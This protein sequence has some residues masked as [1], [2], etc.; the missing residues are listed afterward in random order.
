MTKNIEHKICAIFPVPIYFSKL[1]RNFNQVELNAFKD[2]EMVKNYAN[3][4]SKDTYILDKKPLLNLKNE[5]LRVVEDYYE[6]VVS[7][8]NKIKPFITQSWLNYTKENESHHK[9][10]HS[11]SYV[12]G[13]LYIDVD[14]NKDKI[15]FHKDGY[16]A[17][18]P[19]VK[20]H[21]LF[22]SRNWFFPVK[23]FD[24][25]LFPSN[26]SHSVETKSEKNTRISLAFN[27]FF[28]GKIG[29]LGSLTELKI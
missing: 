13:V 4:N 23:N 17:L 12:S 24:I 27:T 10:Y 26:L 11:N 2:L 9:H 15:W 7:P 20:E 25:I 28:K 29:S 6:R 19:E 16:E 18:K 5:L 3:Q 8:S 21:H 22:N 14:E 1:N